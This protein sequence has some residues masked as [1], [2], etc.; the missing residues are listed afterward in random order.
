MSWQVYT[1]LILLI[2]YRELGVSAVSV[3]SLCSLDRL[4]HRA[5]VG[6]NVRQA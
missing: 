4:F 1:A 2:G 6:P 5:S 3:S